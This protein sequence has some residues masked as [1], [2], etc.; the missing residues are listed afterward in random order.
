[1]LHFVF[2]LGQLGEDLF[3]FCGL[4]VV[5]AGSHS[6]VDVINCLGLDGEALVKVA[7]WESHRIT[8][9]DDGP[10]L[11]SGRVGE[12]RRVARRVRRWASGL[13]RIGKNARNRCFLPSFGSSSIFAD[14]TRAQRIAGCAQDEVECTS[15]CF[16][17]GS[18]GGV[19]GDIGAR[20]SS[21]RC[22][23]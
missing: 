1:V 3:A 19:N 11:A 4:F 7:P 17:R 6:S 14:L 8:H 9:D 18:F 22:S 23:Q 16:W 15:G 12:R 2:K 20:R 10:S 13:A 21:P 5:V